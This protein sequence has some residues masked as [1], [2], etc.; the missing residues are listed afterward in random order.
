M[1]VPIELGSGK[2]P[3]LLSSVCC[4]TAVRL[5]HSTIHVG[6]GLSRLSMASQLLGISNDSSWTQA[7]CLYT[8]RAKSRSYVDHH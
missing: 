7:L 4:S 8:W 1:A 5:V 3:S 6:S 2:S